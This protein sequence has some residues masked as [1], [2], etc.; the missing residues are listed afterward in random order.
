MTMVSEE[1]TTSPALSTYPA[2][3]VDPPWSY[4]N[5]ATRGAAEDH[6]STMSLEDIKAMQIPSADDCHLYLW[7]TNAFIR[8]GFDVLGAWGFTYKTCLTWVKPQLGLGNY[9]R[10]ATEHVLFAI[11]GS[12]PTLRKDVPTWFQ[13][14]RRRHSAK[15]ELFYDIVERSS[16]GPYLEMFA[17]RRRFNWDVWGDEA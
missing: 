7:V 14:K 12:L 4:S 11:K 10:N 16:P 17:R 8:E 13:A 5:K 3:V 2:I 1:L 15:P 6:Y 9:F